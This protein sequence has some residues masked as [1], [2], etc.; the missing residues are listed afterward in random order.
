MSF[1]RVEGVDQE[2]MQ[3]LI[4]CMQVSKRDIFNERQIRMIRMPNF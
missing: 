2:Q 1:F 3:Q 4:V